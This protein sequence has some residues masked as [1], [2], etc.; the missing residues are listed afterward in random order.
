MTG[1]LGPK[2]GD[3]TG[4]TGQTVLKASR[5]AALGRLVFYYSSHFLQ[6]VEANPPL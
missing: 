6:S 4:Q 5:A 1:L 3:L 2:A